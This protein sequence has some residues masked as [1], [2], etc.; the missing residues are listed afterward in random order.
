MIAILKVANI[1]FLGVAVY[2]KELYQS[3]ALKVSLHKCW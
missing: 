2:W 3:L 1:I